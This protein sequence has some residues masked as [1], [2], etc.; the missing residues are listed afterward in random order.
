MIS[1]SL[2]FPDYFKFIFP[3]RPRNFFPLVYSELYSIG[4]MAEKTLVE[5]YNFT[6]MV[7]SRL[8]D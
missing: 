8:Y 6:S 1:K 3:D 7:D 5:P 2:S 4:K